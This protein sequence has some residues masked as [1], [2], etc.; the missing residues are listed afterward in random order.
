M[1]PSQ[2]RNGTALD[3]GAM[4]RLIDATRETRGNDKTGLAEIMRQRTGEFEPGPRRIARVD[5]RDHRPHQDVK[6]A[7][8]A[9][10]RRRI[11]EGCKSWRIAGLAG[12][13]E[14]DIKSF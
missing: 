14:A 6:R 7:A 3:A 1:A 12:C 5:D 11:I 13:D 2:H 9:E 10:Q 4:R 8:H